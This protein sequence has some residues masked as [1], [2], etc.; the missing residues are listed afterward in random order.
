M[1]QSKYHNTT[2]QLAE[3][4]RA[5][6]TYVIDS[7]MM[8]VQIKNDSDES[9]ILEHHTH[10]RYVTECFEEN[11]YLIELNAHE[12]SGKV[13]TKIHWGSWVCKA[14]TVMSLLSEIT[15]AAFLDV[16]NN[17]HTLKTNSDI[18]KTVIFS[19]IS[20]VNLSLETV[21]SNSITMYSEKNV[22]NCYSEVVNCYS[23]LW[24]DK[25]CVTKISE[26]NWMIISLVNR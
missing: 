19:V 21:L 7:D 10:L 20:H 15:K 5:I 9:I 18:Q 13:S 3:R 17:S 23:D 8:F 26:L 16:T 22:L 14:L 12:L 24:A 4:D 6:Y 2:Q 11:C 1:F 25:E